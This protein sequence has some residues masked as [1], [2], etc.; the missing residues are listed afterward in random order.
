LV[1]EY[2]EH[3]GVKTHIKEFQPL[4]PRFPNR[5]AQGPTRFTWEVGERAEEGQHSNVFAKGRGGGVSNL[6][7][8]QAATRS[9]ARRLVEGRNL[10]SG[11]P[12]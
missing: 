12:E 8:A 4:D 3:M 10:Y 6:R 7:R 2:G 5:V 9:A 1:E 11:Q